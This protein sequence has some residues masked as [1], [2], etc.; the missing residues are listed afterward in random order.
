[1]ASPL[2]PY[3]TGAGVLSLL[4]LLYLLLW[5]D[6]PAPWKSR[7]CPYQHPYEMCG[8]CAAHCVPPAVIPEGYAD[9]G[10]PA[11]EPE[12]ELGAGTAAGLLAALLALTA[13]APVVGLSVALLALAGVASAGRDIRVCLRRDACP[14]M[15]D[16]HACPYENG[17]SGSEFA[18][19]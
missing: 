4:L 16:V 3:V 9:A 19:Q 13:A 10:W 18:L 11:P 2:L 15:P 17:S 8:V 5:W 1:M 6:A 14:Y 12:L 7:L